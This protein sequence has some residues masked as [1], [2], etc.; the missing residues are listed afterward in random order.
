MHNLIVKLPKLKPKI[1]IQAMSE[2]YDWGLVDLNIPDVH[3]QTL[4]ENIKIGVVDSGKSEHFETIGN[5]AAFKNFSSTPSVAD[6][7]GHA[8]FVSGII[9]AAKDNEGIIGV[10]PKSKLY[11]AKVMEDSGNGDPKALIKGIKWCTEQ[12]VDIISISA[13]LFTDIPELYVAVREAYKQ[14]IIIVAATGN[15]GKRNPDVAFPARYPEVIGVASYDKTHKASSFSSRGVNVKF[16]LPGS[17]IYSTYL[18]NQYCSMSGT[19][20]STPIMAGICALIL[21]TH[22]KGPTTTPCDTPKQMLEHL[23]KYAK[24]LNDDP[25]SVGFGSVNVKQM[26]KLDK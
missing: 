26:F 4:G 10:A 19:S 18:N 12:K 2:T 8:S 21:A 17:D 23:Q 9:A 6:R 14:N 7:Y 11:I 3:K 25:K 15:T 22:R 16:A 5:I 24:K 13:G 20:F 1:V